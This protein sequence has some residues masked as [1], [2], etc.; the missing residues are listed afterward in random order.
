LLDEDETRGLIEALG[1][2]V[3]E[4][5]SADGWTIMEE[6]RWPPHQGSVGAFSRLLDNGFSA[7]AIFP[8]Q[9]KELRPADQ[10]GVFK[11]SGLIVVGRIGVGYEPAEMLV[12]ACTGSKVSG[13]ILN[14]PTISATV[15]A[16]SELQEAEDRLARFAADHAMSAAQ[17]YTDIDSLAEALRECSAVP[18]TG[19]ANSM[20]ATLGIEPDSTLG[21]LESLEAELVPALLAT[22]GR[23]DEARKALAGYISRGGE[24]IDSRE[25]RRF[26]RQLTRWL[27]AGGDLPF[28]S[29]PARW[30]PP[31]SFKMPPQPPASFAEFFSDKDRKAK[32]HADS[33]ARKEA[34]DAVRAASHDKSRDE[35]RALLERELSTRGLTTAPLMV[36]R[37]VEMVLADREP[38]GKTRF[39]LRALR[40]LKDSQA[41]RDHSLGGMFEQ[42][43]GR[44]APKDEPDWL[45]PP[46]RAAYPVWSPGPKWAPV[47]LDPAARAW[48][49]RIKESD[50]R[51]LAGGRELEV[52]LTWDSGHPAADSRLAVHIGAESVGMLRVG[53]EEKF[54][55]VMEAA[56]ERD[57]DPWTRGRL[58]A[59]SGP[60]PYLLEVELPDT[61]GL[62]ERSSR[63]AVRR[64]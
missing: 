37:Q 32:A 13:V 43:E 63:P 9:P 27:N 29:T 24:D 5:L 21:V 2:R 8:S 50:P 36:E 51:Q 19:E 61:P 12:S 26:A 47:E 4:R 56:G 3:T 44:I 48:L 6:R 30:P 23:H 40:Q 57:E 10:E 58:S 38:L 62:P 25:Y 7:V 33:Q 49:D 17:R 31:S 42:G 14:A 52:W 53:V 46:D 60:M 54:W 34:L 15:C 59:I 16:A 11:A 64:R 20:Y 35:V 1:R 22:A 39:A 45:K 18:F 55:P 41:S 28:P